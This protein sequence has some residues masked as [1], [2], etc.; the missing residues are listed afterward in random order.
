MSALAR[1]RP[2]R[3]AWK[4]LAGLLATMEGQ[5][6]RVELKDDKVVTGT[7][8]D[9]DDKMNLFL[10]GA[11]ITWMEGRWKGKEGPRMELVFLA[12]RMVRYIELPATMNVDTHLRRY[13]KQVEGASYS[14]RYLSTR[15]KGRA[16][17]GAT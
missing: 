10:R 1:K 15:N 9:V 13:R 3:G 5:R 12:A 7:I 17:A 2:R 16:A 6:V 4:S 14:R 8:D 11:D